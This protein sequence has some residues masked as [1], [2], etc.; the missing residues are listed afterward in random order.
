MA[1]G[2]YFTIRKTPE[3][4]T[5]NNITG[6]EIQSEK[7]TSVFQTYPFHKDIKELLWF[8]DSPLKN[9]EAGQSI[10]SY[11]SHGFTLTQAD[12]SME[13]PS[14]IFTALPIEFPKN[15]KDVEP[16]P[17]YPT[18]WDLSPLQ[19]G[20]YIKFLENPYNSDF[21]IGYVFLLYYGLERH[22]YQGKWEQAAKVVLELRKHH[23]Q[24]SFQSCSATSI[25]LSSMQRKN[26]DMVLDLIRQSDMKDFPTDIYLLCA[27]SFDIPITAK[28][29][30]RL[31][32]TFNFNNDYY[33]KKHP[34]LFEEVLKETLNTSR[35]RDYLLISDCLN[36]EDIR[37]YSTNRIKV[38]S[39]TSLR[40]IK[41]NIPFLSRSG[42]LEYEICCLLGAT[43]KT[44]KEML[45]AMRKK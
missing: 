30:M 44:L 2:Y 25:V 33:I 41:I 34:E 32:R 3:E 40:E 43:H 7:E 23:K 19:K 27:Y 8:A 35:K 21:N 22:L 14:M 11:N 6:K 39:N 5:Q 45:A 4:L 15:I 24:K 18:Y 9:I 28:D 16:P 36:S 42:L 1:V 17:Y 38:Y 20:V 12:P 31:S 37:S 10:H 26:V 13:E 29:I